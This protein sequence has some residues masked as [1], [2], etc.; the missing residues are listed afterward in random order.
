MSTVKERISLDHADPNTLH[1]EITTMD[2]AL[3]RPWTV[4]RT[5]RR[6]P[7]S[8]PVW[9]EYVCAENNRHVVIGNEDYVVNQADNNLMPVRKGQP[10]PDLRNFEQSRK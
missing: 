7:A 6:D 1:N 8:Q 4:R 5:Y 3:T 9:V 2:H 10:P